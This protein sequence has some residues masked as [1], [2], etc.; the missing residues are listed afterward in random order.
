MLIVTIQGALATQDLT[1][2]NAYYTFDATNRTGTLTFSYIDNGFDFVADDTARYVNLGVIN[3]SYKGTGLN[4]NEVALDDDIIKGRNSG[5]IS[6]W[7]RD[8][9]SWDAK[10]YMDYLRDANGLLVYYDTIG[11]GWQLKLGGYTM[12]PNI[13]QSGLWDGDFHMI[14][15][16]YNTTSDWLYIDGQLN[17]S[18]TGH[19]SR[20]TTSSAGT[21][22]FNGLGS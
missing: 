13:D 4:A 9:D 17:Y 16:V 20:S 1:E 21:L 14:T 5:T 18:D 2:I 7:Y 10:Y 11:K 6:F 19:A 15:F 22:T 12:T 3:D 8:D